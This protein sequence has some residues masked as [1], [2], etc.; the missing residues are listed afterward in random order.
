MSATSS[1]FNFRFENGRRYH[2]YAEGQYPLPNDDV[3]HYRGDVM[4]V[5]IADST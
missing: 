5:V 1:V 3:S 4:N 2:G